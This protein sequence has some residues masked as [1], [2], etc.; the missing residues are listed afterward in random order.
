MMWERK[1]GKMWA[2]AYAVETAL[3][4]GQT[5]GIVKRDCIEYRR[6]I[7]HLTEIVTVSYPRSS[8]VFHSLVR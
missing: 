4:T 5:V 2:T 7:G 3:A 1:N 6:R 8:Q